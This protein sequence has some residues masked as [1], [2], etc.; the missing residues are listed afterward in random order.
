MTHILCFSTLSME[1]KTYVTSH[2][3]QILSCMHQPVQPKSLS[4]WGKVG[5]SLILQH[6][7]SRAGSPKPHTWILE[8]AVI[9]LINVPARIRTRDLWLWYHIEL[10]APTSSTQK[11]KL[12]RKGGQFTYTPTANKV[13]ITDKMD[14]NE[15][16]RQSHFTM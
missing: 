4:W 12:M 11:L 9:I 1:C 10:H 15:L 2:H 13:L 8:W 5:N 7:P 6:S 3:L 14:L 16:A